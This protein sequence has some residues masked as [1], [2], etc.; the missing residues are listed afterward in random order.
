[1][2]PIFGEMTVT[3]GTDEGTFV[4][5]TRLTHVRTNSTETRKGQAVVYAGFQ[6]RGR[7]AA[8]TASAESVWREA[9]IVERDW[10]EI[11]GRWFTGA[12][13]ETGIDVELHRIMN[14]PIVLG[15][16]VPALRAPSASTTVR[17]YGANLPQQ[18]TPA[19][20]DFGAGVTVRRVVSA[21]PEL[22]TVEVEVADGASVGRRD[23]SIG[24]ATRPSALAVY[25][26]IDSI[27]IE[28][29][30]GMARVGGVVFPK[31][32]QQF[33]AIAYHNGADGRAD[34][35]DDVN[36]GPVPVGWSVEEY[37]ATFDDDDIKFV[38]EMNSSGL[39]IPAVDG[40][41]P[42]RSGNRNNIGDVWVVAT[43]KPSSGPP[44]RARAHL[45]VTVPLYMNWSPTMVA[46]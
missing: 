38:G 8:G 35:E 10:S 24:G 41:N 15:T 30:A 43:Y 2:G 34:T 22:L 29:Q 16:D 44:I 14:D 46:R 20:I 32:M 4:T 42:N 13:D 28:P 17:V 7:S 26:R 1:M 45:L 40:P 5:S 3:A 23:L 6:W 27:R 21:T 19:E 25:D 31:K 36:L 11:K 9:A 39:F 37:A 12:Y 33:E 18:I